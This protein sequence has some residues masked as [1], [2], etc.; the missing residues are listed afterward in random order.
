MKATGTA[1]ALLEREKHFVLDSWKNGLR[2]DKRKIHQIREVSFEFPVDSGHGEIV[3]TEDLE[4]F[5]GGRVTVRLGQTVVQSVVTCNIAEPILSA[6]KNGFLEFNVNYATLCAPNFGGISGGSVTISVPQTMAG[7]TAAFQQDMISLQIKQREIINA[8]LDSLIRVGRVLSP[9]SL[10]IL[11]GRYVWSLRL[12]VTVLSDDGNAL[13]ASLWGAIVALHHYRRPEVTVY[14]E[15]I[16]LHHP[17]DRD[18]IPLPLNHFPIAVTCALVPTFLSSATT[19]TPTAQQP[20]VNE[21]RF[22]LDPSVPET[23]AAA[24]LVTVAMN[25]EDQVC[26]VKKHDGAVVNYLED[27]KPM[28]GTLRS[29]VPKM[30]QIMD[31]AITK[32]LA[33]RKSARLNKFSWAQKRTGVGA[34]AVAISN[35]EDESALR[36]QKKP[37]PEV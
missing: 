25:R 8:C 6:P 29:L 32:N 23:T 17:K 14:K 3:S 35:E 7:S 24:G 15:T 11:V 28:L 26:L 36:D 30:F 1:A 4:W 31:S 16:H 33:E 19:T 13:D 5:L 22:V 20:Q 2:H 18:P 10:C 34:A 9:E 37:R 21:C 27:V 12:D